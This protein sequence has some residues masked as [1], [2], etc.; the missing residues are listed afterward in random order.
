MIVMSVT[1][2]WA[3]VVSGLTGKCQAILMT[4]EQAIVILVTLAY[5]AKDNKGH[6]CHDNHDNHDNP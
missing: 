4:V 1:T 6:S 5:Q 3:F 2:I